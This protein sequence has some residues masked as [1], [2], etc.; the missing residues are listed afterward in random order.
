[1][2]NLITR[3]W[4]FWL[5]LWSLRPWSRRR[6]EIATIVQVRSRS[7]LPERL[8]L[9][10]YIVGDPAKWAILQ[11]PCGCGDTIDV[12]L[13]RSRNPVWQFSVVNG[14]PSFHPSLWVPAERCGAHFWIRYG[15]IIWV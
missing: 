13:M 9:A 15:K 10:L 1:M 5:Y 8:G 3:L 14:K 7:E 6:H 2:K 11:C 4:S 12:N